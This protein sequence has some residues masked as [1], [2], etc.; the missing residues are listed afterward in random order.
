[1]ARFLQQAVLH[2]GQERFQNSL[3]IQRAER[4]VFRL[5]RRHDVGTVY[6]A[7]ADGAQSWCY[8]CHFQGSRSK[9]R[10]A[11]ADFALSLTVRYL[12][13]DDLSEGAL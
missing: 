6:I 3:F 2:A 9:I 12:A 13:G 8:L 1:M 4:A 5:Q 10:T 11:A 7:L